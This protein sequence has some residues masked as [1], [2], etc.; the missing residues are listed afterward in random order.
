M[1]SVHVVHSVH[2]HPPGRIKNGGG[3][4]LHGKVVM[5]LQ[6]ESAIPKAEQE[7]DCF[8]KLGDLDGGRGYLGSF[9]VCFEGDD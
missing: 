2:M 7:S 5:N 1:H 6:A 3:A 8:R 9:S 4:N